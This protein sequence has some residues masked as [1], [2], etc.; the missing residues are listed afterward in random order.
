[1]TTSTNPPHPTRSSN[2]TQSVTHTLSH[3]TLR[4]YTPA[5]VFLNRTGVSLATAE[6][7][8]LQLAHAQARDAVHAVLDPEAF[9]HRLRTEIPNLDRNP[10]LT[11]TSAAPN[12]AVYLRRPDL[13][14]TLSPASAAILSPQPCDIAL[15]IADGLAS[16]AIEH[17]AIPL[18][19]ALLPAFAE[20][21]LTLGLLCVVTQARVAIADQIGALIH[22]RLS[23]VLIGERPGLSSSDSLGAYLTWA[24]APERTDAERN[25]ISNIHATGLDYDSASAKI[26]HYCIEARRLQI[27]GT[28][29]KES[30]LNRP[31][32]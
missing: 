15:V 19:A 13:G 32:L 21:G 1:M 6:I 7:L 28:T 22:A 12:R 23:L 4:D 9:T 5:R 10:I 2:R 16:T 26:L 17:H 29:L 20:A 14:R 25:C 18:L 8:D 27:T 30:T 3:G 24:P 11:L 31:A